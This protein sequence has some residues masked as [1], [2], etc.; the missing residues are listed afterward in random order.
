MANSTT[1]NYRFYSKTDNKVTKG[2][3]EYLFDLIFNHKEYKNAELSSYSV[4]MI[5]ELGPDMEYIEFL[6][7]PYKNT[8]FYLLMDD[9]IESRK[10]DIWIRS[11]HDSDYIDRI[12][13]NNE[14]SRFCQ[15][16]YNNIRIHTNSEFDKPDLNSLNLDANKNEIVEY[17]VPGYYHSAITLGRRYENGPNYFAN[18]INLADKHNFEIAEY[19]KLTD[20]SEWYSDQNAYFFFKFLKYKKGFSKIEIFNDERLVRLYDSNVMGECYMMDDWD[21]CIDKKYIEYKQK[22]K[23][24]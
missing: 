21:N 12:A 6:I 18:R 24:R 9:L 3:Y 8:E 19:G 5:F 15:Y 1:Y 16:K 17:K 4:P 13:L 23:Y 14:R 7:E 11:M 2:D 20:C 22:R 10:Y